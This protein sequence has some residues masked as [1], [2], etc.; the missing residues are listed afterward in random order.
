L[1][2]TLIALVHVCI[3]ARMV[4]SIPSLLGSTC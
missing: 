2:C 1:F 3:W 4:H